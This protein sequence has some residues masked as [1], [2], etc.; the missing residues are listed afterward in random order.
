MTG[1]TWDIMM[2]AIPHRY[3]R[4]CVL[5]EEFDRQ[6]RPGFG[7]RIYYDNLVCPV[8]QKYHELLASSQADYVSVLEDDDFPAPDFVD[9]VFQALGQ[10]PDV[11]GFPLL[12]HHDGRLQ[13]PVECSL[14]WSRVG[15][16]NYPHIIVR[17]INQFCPMR[18]ELWQ[19]GTLAPGPHWDRIWA[20]GVRASQAVKEEV[21]I[22]DPMYYYRTASDDTFMTPREPFP[23]PVPA[24]P[25]YPWLTEV[26]S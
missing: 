2:A 14:R 24:A 15:W 10:H 26:T 16:K 8:G 25:T 23:A 6:A 7:V 12:W 1:P 20:E 19:Y 21:W 4:L 11:V 17:D 3:D 5:L 9:R 22:P 18:R 13:P